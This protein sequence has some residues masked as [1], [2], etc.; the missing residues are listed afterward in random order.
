MTCDCSEV[1]SI[2]IRPN[3]LNGQHQGK[4]LILGSSGS[5]RNPLS[6]DC[7]KPLLVEQYRNA[8]PG[9]QLED[10]CRLRQCEGMGTTNNWS[11]EMSG[12]LRR[13]CFKALKDCF[14][15]EVH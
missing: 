1:A 15:R 3:I 11:G 14:I 10:Q 6:D 2:E 12:D 5:T 13:A 9:A 8:P 7:H 4:T